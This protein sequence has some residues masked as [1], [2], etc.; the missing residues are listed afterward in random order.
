M[1]DQS[2][3]EETLRYPGERC[4]QDITDWAKLSI[5]DP[6]NIAMPIHNAICVHAVYE[7]THI[8]AMASTLSPR[9]VLDSLRVL[10]HNH[11]A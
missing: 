10:T 9:K 6:R 3:S 5:M 4:R 8:F 7:N 11:A 1:Y 2:E